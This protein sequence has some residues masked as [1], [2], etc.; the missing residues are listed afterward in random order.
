MGI[1][2]KAGGGG[3]LTI[4]EGMAGIAAASL[5]LTPLCG[6]PEG[7]VSKIAKG[8][9]LFSLIAKVCIILPSGIPRPSGPPAEADW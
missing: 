6:D 1:L 2:W 4:S 9:C 3:G 5:L 7:R 8:G